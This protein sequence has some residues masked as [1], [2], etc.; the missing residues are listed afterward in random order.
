VDLGK[1]IPGKLVSLGWHNCEA[2]FNGFVNFPVPRNVLIRMTKAVTLIFPHQLYRNHPA[3]A[4]GRIIYLVEEWLYFRQYTFHQHKLILHRASMKSY[5]DL[6]LRQGH[7]VRYVDAQVPESDCRVL[8]EQLNVAGYDEIHFTDPVD[9]WLQKRVA[10]GCLSCGVTLHQYPCPNFLQRAEDLASYFDGKKGYHQTDF[11]IRQRKQRKILL[12]GSGKPLGGRWTYDTE[13]RN[14]LPAGKV[15]P[16][17]RLP[18]ESGFLLEAKQYVQRF[19]PDNYGDGSAPC[20]FAVNFE[21]ADQWLEQFLLERFKD[22]GRFEDAISVHEQVLYHSVLTPMLNI[23]L[24]EPAQV[25]DRAL[26]VADEYEVPLPALEGFVRQVMGWREFMQ[27][28]YHREGVKQRTTNYWK[29]KRKMPASFWK[30]KTGILPVDQTIRKVLKNGYCHHIERLMVLGNFM[31]LCEFDPDEVYRWFMEMFID[32]YDWVMVPNVYGMA[33]FADGG[34]MTTKPY[35]SGSNYLMKM[36][37]YP[38]GDWQQV[39]DALFWR[40]M[41][42]HR[43]FFAQN[44]R[45]GMLLRT[46]DNMDPEKRETLLLRAESYLRSLD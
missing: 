6:L 46:L 38:R 1:E 18:V 25:L 5:E 24:L 32:A 3:L 37:D 22:F 29:F 35:I 39:W 31:L 12:D 36:S 30:G 10:E 33:M 19:F 16:A 13:N 2:G 28:I 20:L 7:D 4:K 11:Y 27:I 14:K 40:F 26:S 23:G 44:P 41:H 21:E 17:L 34:L 45:L 43:S 15:P 42:V 8:I 9:N